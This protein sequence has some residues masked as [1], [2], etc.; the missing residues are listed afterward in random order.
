MKIFLAPPKRLSQGIH[1]VARA[2]TRYK[3]DWASL[4]DTP[5][6]ADLR[7]LHVVGLQDMEEWCAKG[8]YALIQYC[9]KTA[10]EHVSGAA[11]NPESNPG[12]WLPI[13]QRAKSIWSYY[14]LNAYV[15]ETRGVEGLSNFYYAPLGVDGDVFVPSEPVRKRFIIGTSGY[16]AD[17]EAVGECHSAARY[18]DRMQLHLG[19]RLPLGSGV[20]YINSVSDEQLAEFWS[21]CSFVAGLR[22]FEGFELPALEGL[23]CGARPIMF[24]APHY[25]AWFD[26][27]AEFIP[28]AE[29]AVVTEHLIR[30]FEQPVRAVTP[31]ERSHALQK[32]DWK[33][34]VTGFWEALR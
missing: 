13:W 29:P 10:E 31:A 11:L 27:H 12:R 21:Q 7:V 20:T 15:R 30:L 2:M 34:L 28:E 17:S 26:G 18:V 9:L 8:P 23:M 16:V 5:E 4:V 22:R 25:R 6:E 24:D 3:P 19:P 33:N 14:D 1:R 32:F